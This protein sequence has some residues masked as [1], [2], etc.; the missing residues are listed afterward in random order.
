MKLDTCRLTGA[1]SAVAAALHAASGFH[2][3]W[4]AAAFAELIAM[5]GA[6]G[7]LALDGETPIG[8]V[9]WRIAADEGEILTICTAPA[10]R[11][12]GA[13]GYLL[14]TAITVT[15]AAGARRLILEVAVD[16]MAAIALYRAFGFTEVGRRGGYYQ[17]AEGP[18]DALILTREL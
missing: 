5:P 12:H 15:A 13:G 16:N 17:N 3:T 9:L 14:D 11:R 2:E 1:M 7:C 6:G 4:D 18:V 10:R 8:L